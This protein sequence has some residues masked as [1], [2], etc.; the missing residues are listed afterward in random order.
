MNQLSSLAQEIHEDL[1]GEFADGAT[2]AA[3]REWLGEPPGPIK[4][5]LRELLEGK[6][7]YR[8]R[9]SFYRIDSARHQ[10][11]TVR[12][13]A[14]IERRLLLRCPFKTIA[15][16]LDISVGVVECVARDLRR[17]MRLPGDRRAA[18]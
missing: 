5:A 4:D 16:D 17:R 18:P 1:T 12:H 8:V 10:P 14:E 6:R 7:I 13:R 3:L 15:S 9:H 11:G 2:V